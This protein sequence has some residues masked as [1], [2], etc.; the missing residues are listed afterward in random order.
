MA[1]VSSPSSTAFHVAK[2]WAARWK[3]R[4]GLRQAASWKLLIHIRG[5]TAQLSWPKVSSG[6][7]PGPL[8]PL[9]PLIH[10]GAAKEASSIRALVMFGTEGWVVGFFV[11]AGLCT[12]NLVHKSGV[13]NNP[14][15]CP[16]GASS[17]GDEADRHPKTKLARRLREKRETVWECALERVC[18][19]AD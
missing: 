7:F 11:F 18:L 15:L 4:A 12:Q 16:F 1:F 3:W 8:S 13:G 19:S 14:A 9:L 17:F 2:R 6:L 10:N 5:G